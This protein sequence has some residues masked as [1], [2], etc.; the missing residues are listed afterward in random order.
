MVAG[1]YSSICYLAV[2]IPIAYIYTK[3]ITNCNGKVITYCD[4]DDSRSRPVFHLR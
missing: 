3:N 1:G 4:P 2:A